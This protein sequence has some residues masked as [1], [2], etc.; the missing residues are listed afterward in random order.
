[1]PHE[2]TNGPEGGPAFTGWR[3]P[4]LLAKRFEDLDAGDLIALVNYWEAWPVHYWHERLVTGGTTQVE[5][6]LWATQI[7][8][9]AAE[10][11]SLDP[12]AIT[13]AAAVVRQYVTNPS[14]ARY[15]TGRIG[16]MPLTAP[17]WIEK[18][19]VKHRSNDADLARIVDAFGV[20]RRLHR[21]LNPSTDGGGSPGHL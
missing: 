11:H 13:Q 7:L 17:D 19:P 1:M 9:L 10:A 16:T 20:L 6:F 4:D 18:L 15:Y 14:L 12:E 8:A 3:R 21:K 2:M 5:A